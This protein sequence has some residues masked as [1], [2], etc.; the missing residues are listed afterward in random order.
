MARIKL[1]RLLSSLD[2]LPLLRVAEVAFLTPKLEECANFY[3]M[4]GLDD[5]SPDPDRKMIHFA[6]VG[7]QYFG[8]A[9]EE[10]GFFSGYDD[11]NIKV[12]LHIAFEVADNSL[13]ECITFLTSKGVK[14]SPK[15]KN[16]RDWHGAKQPYS[17]YFRDPHGNI[18]ELWARQDSNN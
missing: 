14:C 5:F 10:R 8:F 11:E 16:S 13:N 4:L 9:D 15:I 12:P 3:R 17:V 2:K 18:M 6:N 1:T 7:E